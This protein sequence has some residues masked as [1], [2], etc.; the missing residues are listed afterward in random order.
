M[1]KNQ[2]EIQT[3]QCT[4]SFQ[5]ATQEAM[6]QWL[7]SLQVYCV[8]FNII[9]L[10]INSN[11]EN[12]YQDNALIIFRNFLFIFFYFVIKALLLQFQS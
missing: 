4:Y 11:I 12:S 2:F 1:S 8:M 3:P 9:I 7:D 5:A 10:L 6:F